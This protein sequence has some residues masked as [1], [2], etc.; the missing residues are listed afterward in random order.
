MNNK[1]TEIKRL[2]ENVSL[3]KRKGHYL[4]INYKTNRIVTFDKLILDEVESKILYVSQKIA[5]IYGENYIV[6]ELTGSLN[7]N[8]DVC[9]YFYLGNCH[10]ESEIV[11]QAFY[12]Q[13]LSVIYGKALTYLKKASI[14]ALRNLKSET[15]ILKKQKCP[16]KIKKRK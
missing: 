3:F 16:K 7:Y 14:K 5:L 12:H 6:E 13:D 10:Y 9:D 11:P 15:L 2:S 8:G 4:I 1:L